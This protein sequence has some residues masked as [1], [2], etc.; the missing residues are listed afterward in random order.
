MESRRLVMHK[1]IINDKNFVSLVELVTVFGCVFAPL[2]KRD[3]R[4]QSDIDFLDI[5]ALYYLDLITTACRVF[6]Y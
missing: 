1:L 4:A 5:Y 2:A 3:T 6:Y